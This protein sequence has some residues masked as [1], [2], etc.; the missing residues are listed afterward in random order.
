MITSHTPTWKLFRVE[1]PAEKRKVN[2]KYD[3][4]EES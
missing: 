1:T 4:P 3:L 2:R